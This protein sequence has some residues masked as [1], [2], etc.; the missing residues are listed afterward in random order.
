MGKTTD[1]LWQQERG[2]TLLLFLL[3]MI[4][5]FTFLG[6]GID[7]GF[8]Y[9]S[10]AKLSK[11]VDAACLTGMRSLSQGIPQA[12][13]VAS[14]AFA[15]NYGSSG[16]DVAPPNP[17]ITFSSVNGNTV[18]DVT[19]TVNINTFF[20]RALPALPFYSGQ[21]WK[22]LTVGSTA[23]ATRA[24]LIMALVLDDS[25][26]MRNN[27]GS[28]ALPGAVSSFISQFSP[29]IDQL[30]M[31]T[32]DSAGSVAVPMEYNFVTDINNAVNA[33][34]FPSTTCSDQGLTNGFAQILNTP[35][36]AN[37]N[38]IQV[39]VFFTDG[40]ANTF[41]YTFNCGSRNID[42]ND[43]LYDPTTGNSS[44]TGCT[45]PGTISSINPLNGNLTANAVNTSSCDAMHT[46]AENRAEWIAWLARNQNYII[47]SIGMGSPGDTGECNGDF[48]VLNPVFLEDVANTTDSQTYQSTQ[49]AGDY[50]VA[51]DAGQLEQVFQTIASKILLR[52]TK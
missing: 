44:S 10:R 24:N 13:V 16:R 37:E 46:E 2:Q 33:M 50:A 35:V 30:A 40:M 6:L 20:L 52:L 8:A 23:E 49:Q 7:L 28:G 38:V 45:I 5:L 42:Y 47:Y 25:G 14:N 26:S 12:T 29:T 11:A 51:A 39:L 48:P 15:A 31:V 36:T 32:F 19:A 21:S 18:L 3:F 17:T 1:R 9:I 34:T 22:T 4:V 27:G 41:N 43:N